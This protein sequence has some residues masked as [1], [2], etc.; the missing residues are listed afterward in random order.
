MQA[1]SAKSVLRPSP[2]RDPQGNLICLLTSAPYTDHPIYE[3]QIAEHAEKWEKLI[4]THA[5]KST[6]VPFRDM[7]YWFAFDVMGM[8]MLSE[9]F[10]M[11]SSS[12]SHWAVDNLRRAMKILGPCQMTPWL[13]QIGFKY[14]K[15]YWLVRD[16]HSTVNWCKERLQDRIKV[17]FSLQP[18]Q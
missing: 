9:S 3:S 5:D 8:F 11:I 18:D 10:N 17:S 14:L 2:F 6:M 13:A 15:G 7:A 1:V 16:W 4:R 12:E